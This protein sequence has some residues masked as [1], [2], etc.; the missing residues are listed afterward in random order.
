MSVF[1]EAL[2]IEGVAHIFYPK[3]VEI[4][5]RET[6]SRNVH[7]PDISNEEL[8]LPQILM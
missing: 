8:E 5:V 1:T 4:F 7:A 6:N 3:S 2:P